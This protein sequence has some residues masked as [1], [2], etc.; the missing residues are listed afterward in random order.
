MT[1]YRQ[2]YPK[3]VH[4]PDSPGTSD[5]ALIMRN[6]HDRRPDPIVKQDIIDQF[7]NKKMIE[8]WID[9]RSSIIMQVR[10]NG[11]PVT[12]VGKC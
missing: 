7:L 9:D 5:D 3:T 2:K 10:A 11:I 12:D 8:M 4:L 6:A 1:N